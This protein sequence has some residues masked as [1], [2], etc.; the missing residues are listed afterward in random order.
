MNRVGIQLARGIVVAVVLL[1]GG[2]LVD[3]GPSR[4]ARALALVRAQDFT[5]LFDI[6]GRRVS[7]YFDPRKEDRFLEEA[8]SLS[9]KWKAVT[10]SRES[11]EKHV[12]RIFE[13]HVFSSREFDVVL[14]QIRADFAY[15]TAATENRL[16]VALYDDVRV[17]RPGLS[18]D[19]FKTRYGEIAATLAPQ[20]L[21]DLGMNFVSFAGSDAAAVLLVAAL[22]SAGILGTSVAAGGAGGPV[23]FGASLAIGIVAGIAL[24]AIVGDMYEDA[25]RIEVRRHI[26]TLRNRLIDEV[27]DALV[28]ALLAYRTLQE[29]CLVE[30]Y[31][32]GTNE[33]LAR[34]S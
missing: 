30:L 11:Y 26:C 23:T 13:K 34:R 24:D 14:D 16:L 10:R 33:R 2:P 18:F 31:E 1:A 21:R 20:V 32:G 3:P 6:A 8:F 5:P 9:G 12:R 28:K 22:S 29:R 4:T 15:G 17:A 19:K 7:D 27:H 25:A